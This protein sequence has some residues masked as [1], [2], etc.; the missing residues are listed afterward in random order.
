MLNIK[1]KIFKILVGWIVVCGFW[2]GIF[3]VIN[4]LPSKKTVHINP[5]VETVFYRL[6]EYKMFK[7]DFVASENNLKR[8]DVLFKNPNLESKDELVVSIL[9]DNKIIY[10]QNFSGF[11]FGDTSHARLDF[12]SRHDSLNKKYTIEIVATKIVDG[13]L[14]FGVRND[15][16]DLTEYYENKFNVKHSISASIML[17]QNWLLL[18]PLITVTLLLW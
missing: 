13:K 14:Y 12:V 5:N 7:S 3:F 2:F 10:T 6:A 11:N 1:I 15:E 9:E 16:I 17:M 8:I 18:L 4:L